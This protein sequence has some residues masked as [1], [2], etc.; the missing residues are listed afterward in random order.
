MKN[1]KFVKILKMASLVI[2]LFAVY[3]QATYYELPA[4]SFNVLTSEG[5]CCQ[6][7][8]G[9]PF[10]VVESALLANYNAG[11]LLNGSE[12]SIN[13]LKLL[14]DAVINNR[15]IGIYTDDNFAHAYG[16]KI[17]ENGYTGAAYKILAIKI[18]P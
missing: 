4:G 9:F 13:W 15:K 6:D 8:N 10:V 11:F 17:A 18:L 2:A 7:V 14:Q 3:S 12:S 5:S 16:A 1:S